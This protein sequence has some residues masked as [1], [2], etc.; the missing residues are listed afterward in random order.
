VIQELACVGEKAST[1]ANGLKLSYK[2][3]YL[4]LKGGKL[5]RIKELSI[6]GRLQQ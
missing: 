1:S 2:A 3:E 5:A 6:I 4:V